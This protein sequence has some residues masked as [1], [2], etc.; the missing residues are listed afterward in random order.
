MLIA[1]DVG[2]TNLDIG[3]FSDNEL[4]VHWC[5]STNNR[6][7]EDE[8]GLQLR[9]LL[10][11]IQIDTTSVTGIIISCVVPPLQPV[12]E[13]M[14]KKYFDVTPIT[15]GPGVKTG[16]NIRSDN[17]KEVGSDRIV[18]AVA[19]IEEYSVPLI[20]VSVGTATTFCYIDEK[21]LYMGGVIAPGPG[22]SADALYKEA[23]KLPLVE[24]S[25]PKRMIGKNTVDALQSGLFYGFIGQVEGVLYRL[26]H[27]V[28]SNPTVVATGRYSDV[29]AEAAN[30]VDR[31]DPHLTLKGLH[32]I[33][34]K[35]M[36]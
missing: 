23:S 6:K 1:I 9:E 33:Y 4:K 35:N 8:Y 28:K 14:G 3:L 29:V 36:S 7:T 18:N 32:Y 2:N 30:S 24:M 22:V 20:I 11:S 27:E 5:L 17:P 12:L 34:Q 21:C 26:K 10:R 13:K 19:A 15:V 31:V 16:L 25:K